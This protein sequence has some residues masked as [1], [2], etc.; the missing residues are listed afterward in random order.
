MKGK[1]GVLVAEMCTCGWI[2]NSVCASGS[3]G[4]N[5]VMLM[6]GDFTRPSEALV[7]M[8][9]TLEAK[10]EL[11]GFRKKRNIKATGKITLTRL[12]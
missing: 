2:M 4:T 10:T 6:H 12:L 8:H 3:V 5:V 11:Q 7:A 9:L 1:I